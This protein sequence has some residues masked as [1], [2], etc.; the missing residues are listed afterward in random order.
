MLGVLAVLREVWAI[1]WTIFILVGVCIYDLCDATLQAI[2]WMMLSRTEWIVL[3]HGIAS[4]A[5]TKLGFGLRLARLEERSLR[6]TKR[7]GLRHAE[8]AQKYNLQHIDRMQLGGMSFK[9]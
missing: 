6:R 3:I 2:A 8:G 5:L 7:S 4:L 9:D 1:R